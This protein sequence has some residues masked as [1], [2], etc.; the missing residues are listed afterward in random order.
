MVYRNQYAEE[1]GN[2]LFLERLSKFL[3][4]E[5]QDEVPVEV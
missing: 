3:S 1:K 2:P 4:S 5:Y